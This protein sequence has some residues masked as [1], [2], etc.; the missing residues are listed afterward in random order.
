[1]KKCFPYKPLLIFCIC[2][3]ICVIATAQ[4][5]KNLSYPLQEKLLKAN[6]YYKLADFKKAVKLYLIISEK[7]GKDTSIMFRIAYSF[8][9]LNDPKNAEEWYKK[10]I[11]G[12]EKRVPPFH[13][14]CY[15]E[16][17]TTN[18]KYSE[19]LRWYK[20][21]VKVAHS[22]DLRAKEAIQ[23]LEHIADFYV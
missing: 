9:K 3:L 12:N 6:Q 1:M 17:L 15:A 7:S 23:S 4:T 8:K 5:G 11:T 19:A 20:E 21:Y 14:L 13:R 16:I 2:F 18:G 10:A 22:S